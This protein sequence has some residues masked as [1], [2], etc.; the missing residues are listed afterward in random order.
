[1]SKELEA[2]DNTNPREA[3]EC[4]GIIGCLITKATEKEYIILEEDKEFE[5]EYNT[6]KQTLLQAE[7]DKDE[8]NKYRKLFATPLQG[9]IRELEKANKNKKVLK[10]INKIVAD[11]YNGEIDDNTAFNIIDEN[12]KD[13]DWS[14]TNEANK[15]N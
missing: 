11:Y 6:I 5:E 4:L 9:L 7:R 13:A 1:M 8:L 10:N 15:T 12:L 3:L 2:I 14:D